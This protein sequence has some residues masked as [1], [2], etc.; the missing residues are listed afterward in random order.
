MAITE[1][2]VRHVAKLARLK[3]SDE[4]IKQF[5]RQ[6]GDILTY[7][8]KLGELD[9]TD[10]EPTAHAAPIRNVFRDDISRP[11]IGVE[12]VLANAPTSKPPFFKVP[13]VL[14]QDHSGG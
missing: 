5:A 8:E 6:L 10:I 7:V 12:K 11:G 13:K 3:L 9:T 4:Q 2:D 14:D 1:A